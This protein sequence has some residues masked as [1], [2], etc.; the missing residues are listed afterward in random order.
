MNIRAAVIS[1]G[2]GLAAIAMAV[3][4]HGFSNYITMQNGYF[5]DAGT[6]QAFLPHGV[7]YQTWNRPLGVWQTPNQIDYDLDEF[8]KLGGNSIRVDFV[9]QSIQ[10]T[11]QGQ[12]SWSNYDYLLSSAERHGIRVFALIGYQFPPPW[13]PDNY[14]TMH[15]PYLDSEG[16]FHTNYWQSDILRYEDPTVQ[17]L[18]TNFIGAVCS[19]YSTNKAVVAWVIGNEYGYLGLWSG[20]LD[21]Y[22]PE[23]IQ[24]FQN[25]CQ[26]NYTTIANVNAMWGTSFGSFSNITLVNQYEAY[27]PAGA[28]WVDMGQWRES[29]IAHFTALGAKAAR[30]NDPNHLLTYSTVGMQWGE[31]DWRWHFESRLR[32]TQQC[33]AMGAPL[34]F[35]S[36]NNYPWSIL[37][38]ESQQGRWGV[39]YTKKTTGL[40]VAYSETGFTSSETLWPGMD[41]TRQGPLIRNTLWEGLETGIIGTHVFTWQDRVYITPR[42]QGFGIVT[43]DRRIKPAYWSVQEAYDLMYQVGLNNLLQGSTDP[44]PDVAFL[45]TDAND[46]QHNRYECE[47]QQMAGAFERLGFKPTWMNLTDLASGSYTNYKVLVLPRNMRVDNV[48]TN[49]SGTAMGVLDFIRTQVMPAGVDVL[50]SAD[51]P[52]LQDFHGHP[53]TNYISNLSS[54]FGIDTHDVGGYQAPMRTGEYVS[55]YW[56]PIDITFTNNALG[57][58]TN[59]YDYKPQVWKYSDEVR[60]TNSSVL[61][62]TMDTERN[63]GF[64][65][66]NT[67]LAPWSSWG[68]TI[69]QTNWGWQLEGNNM[70]QMWG[71][72]GVWADFPAVPFG[73]Y[74]ASTYLRN[75]NTD[76][77]LSNSTAYVS[78]E[79]YDIYSNYLG[80]TKSP[81][82]T[83]YTPSNTWVRYVAD[84]TAPNN[85][86][87][88]RRVIRIGPGNLLTNDTLQGTGS[89]PAGW[90]NWNPSNQSSDVNFVL[91]DETNTWMFWYDAGIW[92][93]VT[94]GFSVGDTL[95]FGGY[96]LSP[97]WDP[98]VGGT[99]Y[100]VVQLE[101]FNGTNLLSTI[102][103]SPTVS[104]STPTDIWTYASGTA[105]VPA[106]A[107]DARLVVRC[108]NFTSGNGRFM[109]GDVFIQNTSKGGGSVYVDDY[110]RDPAVVVNSANGAKSAIF[111]Y[112]FGDI[113]PD[114][115]YDGLMDTWPWKWR[116]DVLGSI[117]ENYFG[118]QPKAQVTGT[119][120]FLCL[121]EWRTCADSSTVWMI[122]NYQYIP[123]TNTGI[124]VG[125]T[126][127]GPPEVFTVTSSM[128]TGKTVEAWY[129][130]QIIATNCNG[131]I[132]LTLPPDGME[133]LHVYSGLATQ[134]VVIIN[135]APDAVYP[136]GSETYPVL[137]QYDTRGVPLTLNLSF[138]GGLTN[139]V[140]QQLS[141]NVTGVGTNT[142]WIWIP[143]AN[144][145]DPNYAS[146][147]DG[148][149]YQF[150]SWLS[151]SS[152]NTV[153]KSLPYPTELLWGIRPITT[154]PS[155]LTNG[156][157][158][159]LQLTW[160][161]L[162]EPYWW[163]D[164]TVNRNQGYPA[165]VAVF[166]SLKTEAQ[167]P[168]HLARVNQVCNWLESMSYSNNP[169][170]LAFSNLV[171]AGLFTD[172]FTNVSYTNNWFREAGASNW[173]D[174]NKTLNAWRIGNNDNMLSHG[175]LSWSNV[176]AS[177]WFRYNTQDYYFNDADL[178]VNFQ[179]R[180]NYVC[181]GMQNYYGEWQVQYTVRQGGYI[182]LFG[183]METL[184]KTNDPSTNVWYQLGVSVQGT[185]YTVSYN[186]QVLG[187]FGYNGF[188][189]GKVAL[190]TRAAQLG[191]F[192]P[193][194]G[195]YFID[196]DELNPSNTA[197]G[198]ID[199]PVN[200]DYGY[201]DGFFNTLIL[202]SVGVMSDVEISNVTTWVTNGLNCL[203]AT[204]GGVGRTE[205]SGASGAGRI[206]PL[207]GVIPGI[208]V[209][210][211][212]T[213]LTIGS[214]T[215]YVTHDYSA[216]QIVSLVTN[217]AANAWTSLNGASALATANSGTMTVPAL[218]VNTFALNTNAPAK[219]F[220][221]NVA[222]DTDGLLTN[223]LSLLA[224]RAFQWGQQNQ[225]LMT[226]QLKYQAPGGANDLVLYTTNMWITSAGGTNTL[227]FTL[228]SSGLMTGTNLYWEMYIAPWDATN[229]WVDQEGYYSSLSNSPPTTLGGTGLQIFGVTTNAYG[230]RGWDMWIGYNTQG[231]NLTLAFGMQKQGNILDAV[232]FVN[233]SFS[234]W[235]TNASSNV[236]WSFTSTN[237]LRASVIGSLTND[238][239]ITR[240]SLNI[241]NAPVTYDYDVYFGSN[242]VEGGV[243]YRG[244]RMD[245]SPGKVG[246]EDGANN[247]CTI[248][249]LTTNVVH[250]IVLTVRG[251][252]PWMRSD[253]YVDG[254]PQLLDQA[255][256]T[257]NWLSSTV[258]FFSPKTK[259]YSEWANYHVSDEIFAM[260]TSNMFGQLV[261]TNNY[262][263]IYAS[264][265]D[266]DPYNYENQ[267]TTYGSQYKWYAYFRGSP[268]SASQGANVYFAPRFMFEATNFPTLVQGGTTASVPIVWENLPQTPVYMNL[269]FNQV[270]P[271]L[272]VT[273]QVFTINTTW[274]TNY[275]PLTIPSVTVPGSNY[276]WSAYM[277]PTTATNPVQQCIGV[278]ASYYFDPN[279]LP[280]SAKVPILVTNFPYVAYSDLG[281]PSGD[282]VY[283]WQYIYNDCTFNGVY[284]GNNPPEGTN[285]F[286]TIVPNVALNYGGW[287]VFTPTTAYMNMSK[288]A[289]GYLKFWLNSTTNIE[290]QVQ[291]GTVNY[292]D[293]TYMAPSTGGA[294]QQF[295]VP[296]TTFTSSNPN[297]NLSVMYGLFLATAQVPTTFYVDFVRW[298]P[299]P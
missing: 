167:Y 128:F 252:A 164:T 133:M 221:L 63:K 135:D 257:T 151:N 137:V 173:A 258:G 171:V 160:Q 180:S 299:S 235:T 138:N 127:G 7:A 34:A 90:Y 228:P 39:N 283:T 272:V 22:D 269:S 264:V 145:S 10:A 35:F 289:T 267:G 279:G 122:K 254:E 225:F 197:T 281:I 52:G 161:N 182:Q 226:L 165:R 229:A 68:N 46:S 67:S 215:H 222:G 42:E 84:N 12:F 243:L 98:L 16:F 80:K 271:G 97:D 169:L 211:N 5:Y 134:P 179:N 132:T 210:S 250:Q 65:S 124:F 104:S 217:C 43:A 119:N 64:E 4:A 13:F 207:F 291:D 120:A 83:T 24:S 45:W 87:R 253:L 290:I 116:Y 261:P 129:A 196:D 78:I 99:K 293:G 1:F 256:Q 54:I 278:D 162:P 112:S 275:F 227:N 141:T 238:S 76:P 111:L 75:N 246:W 170:N 2:L 70:L 51:L 88:G 159:S 232:N 186:G 95:S 193:Q 53:T 92:Q 106:G 69:L 248:T 212:L 268:A 3:P 294:W 110:T 81:L 136:L 23:S 28:E 298:S 153:L 195:Y 73:E 113:N 273:S 32:I 149:T 296:I 274:G 118:L 144:Q 194:L 126:N 21:G 282:S 172:N 96:L 143:G 14:Y 155:S 213:S 244:V 9:W 202:S 189:S 183:L 37:G 58:V 181:V 77:L 62:A 230:G 245:I 200:L 91:G 284:T 224:Q 82:L 85:T 18:Y 176:S 41:E 190:G 174:T 209:V 56:A 148:G 285:D 25:Y 108:N 249:N 49:K 276:Y 187:S 26:T 219:V 139:K 115:D 103:A 130:G 57:A 27:G 15:P 241:S 233:K 131:T 231:T 150:T 280:V 154:V 33:A 297:L 295:S 147:E 48:I 102:S 242:A 220:C 270:W 208:S 260:A 114:G 175:S 259:G 184:D 178:Y 140:Y 55:W 11:S 185:N 74:T 234:G 146:T 107:N 199:G 31:E 192:D 266:Y 100:G 205:P 142:F 44:T 262:P 237:R 72:S 61:W 20:I 240:T 47:M 101:F 166:R 105:T 29:S 157:P 38:H 201:L 223:A 86:Y 79:W 6:G 214:Q 204:D 156:Q 89:V 59:N 8:V 251:G 188:T 203:I 94:N 218:L 71:D 288:Y 247:F 30:N 286:Q 125:T 117:M 277:Y 40:P 198:V 255:I 158:V 19:R 17:T 93:D 109:A 60:L 191:T 177:V 265:A 292:N 66:S 152:S 236:A 216:G 50:A 36:V 263:W 168:G 163:A 206:E 123:N 121:P 287:G 239:T